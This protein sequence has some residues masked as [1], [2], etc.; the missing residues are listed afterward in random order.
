MLKACRMIDSV[1]PSQEFDS[2][3][4]IRASGVIAKSLSQAQSLPCLR[5]FENRVVQRV[6]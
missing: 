2:A 3:F 4:L 5:L 1:K 6:W